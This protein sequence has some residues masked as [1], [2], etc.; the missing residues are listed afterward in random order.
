MLDAGLKRDFGD[1]LNAKASDL[2]D[3]SGNWIVELDSSGNWRRLVRTGAINVWT[4]NGHMT[5]VKASVRRRTVI[6]IPH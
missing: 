3:S 1:G 2:V 5:L 4:R 6:R